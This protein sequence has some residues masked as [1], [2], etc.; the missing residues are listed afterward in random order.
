MPAAGHRYRLFF[1]AGSAL[2]LGQGRAVRQALRIGMTIDAIQRSVGASG[3]P[4]FVHE[5][6]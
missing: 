2:R 1:V 3:E 6:A 4:D 5:Q